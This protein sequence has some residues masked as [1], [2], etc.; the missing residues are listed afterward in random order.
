[1]KALYSSFKSLRYVEGLLSRWAPDFQ[2]MQTAWGVTLS[3]ITR[4]HWRPDFK[5]M[6]TLSGA[7]RTP[8]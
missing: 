6:Q 5:R 4:P 8:H 3:G 1:M 2:R 7:F